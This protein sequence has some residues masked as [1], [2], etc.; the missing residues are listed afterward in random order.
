MTR[1]AAC[2]G[3]AVGAL[4]AAAAA[5]G[6]GG[7]NAQPTATRIIDR[8]VLCE[9]ANQGVVHVLDVYGQSRIPQTASNVE[10]LTELQPTPR[11]AM[12]QELELT[13]KPGCRR[14]SARVPLT[15][16]GL[17]GGVADQFGDT[18]ACVTPPIVLIRVRAVFKSP[19]TLEF[20]RPFGYPLLF[21]RGNVKE[22]SITVRTRKGKQVV[23]ATVS[24]ARAR[25]FTRTQSCIPK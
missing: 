24:G 16:K 14:S 5:L 20:G 9:V 18:Y 2:L 6:M 1:R 19:V 7:A 11:L 23:H 4:V 10:V 8:T 15:S 13:L 3:L 25:L 22:G 21:A 12:V 17:S